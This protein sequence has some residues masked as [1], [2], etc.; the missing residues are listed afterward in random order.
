MSRKQRKLEKELTALRVHV[1]GVEKKLAK[2]TDRA[3]RWKSE[4]K[5]G[6]KSASA[7]EAR[8]D[9]LQQKLDRATAARP[10][11]PTG[12]TGP[13]GDTADAARKG[14]T[15][16]KTSRRAT[17]AKTTSRSAHVPARA[18]GTDPATT[19]NETWTVAQLRAEARNRGLTGM[20]NKPKAQLL[21]AL[22]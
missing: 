8:A 2:A 12:P 13:T 18:N 17:T 15:K 14:A 11:Q 19:P 3:D 5:A 22:T 4:A 21:S 1:R 7:T 10:A 20:S 16:P 6:R 9:K